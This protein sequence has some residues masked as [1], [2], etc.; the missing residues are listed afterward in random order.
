MLVGVGKIVPVGV[1]KTGWKGVGVG[2]AAGWKGVEV[3]LALGLAVTN[4]NGR[5]DVSVV[6]APHELLNKANT[7]RNKRSVE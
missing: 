1:G 4:V 3:G 2:C 7:N 5:E 6:V